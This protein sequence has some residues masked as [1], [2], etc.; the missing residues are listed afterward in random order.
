MREEN[1]EEKLQTQAAEEAQVL[2]DATSSLSKKRKLAVQTNCPNCSQIVKGRYD[3]ENAGK[4]ARVE[5]PCGT[6]LRLTLP[7]I[8]NAPTTPLHEIPGAANTISLPSPSANDDE[9]EA[10]G[11]GESLDSST[12]KLA[13]MGFSLDK[14]R[15][16][17]EASNGDVDAALEMLLVSQ[18]ASDALPEEQAADMVDTEKE[19]GDE[20]EG[21]GNEIRGARR[22]KRGTRVTRKRG[23]AAA[24]RMG[25]EDEAYPPSRRRRTSRTAGTPSAAA[26]LYPASLTQVVYLDLDN[27]VNFFQ[28]LPGL[29]PE[30]CF[31]HGFHAAKTKY[32]EPRNNPALEKL[33]AAGCWKLHPACLDRRDAADQAI[34][35]Q[36]GMDLPVLP[37]SVAFTVVS[38]DRGFEQ[39][40]KNCEESGRELKL[41]DPHTQVTPTMLLE[42]I[43]TVAENRKPRD[44]SQVQG[45]R[46]SHLLASM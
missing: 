5:C 44:V 39:L 42:L 46:A 15:L 21:E 30:N 7:G 24:D 29:L 22:G 17:L 2:A 43:N 11:Q 31:V 4:S 10:T 37:A 45:S 9:E 35:F 13:E 41:L 26:S 25:D 16:A 20:T 23:R 19:D 27:W 36:C 34:V 33:R 38:G 14:S 1:Q 40:K 8:Q 18:A 32:V 12:V 28:K 3:K 6:Q